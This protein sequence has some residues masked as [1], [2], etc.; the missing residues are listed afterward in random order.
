MHGVSRQVGPALIVVQPGLATTVQDRG[1]PGWQR[2]GVPVSG[3]LDV[4]ALAAA[5]VVV[6]NEIGEAGLECLYRGPELAVR[7]ESVRFAVAGAG[8]GLDVLDADGALIRRCGALESITAAHGERVRVRG[9][10]GS[11]SAYLAIEG[12][13]AVAP[14]LGSRSTY[15]RAGLGGFHGR[16]LRAGDRL[17]LVQ[18]SVCERR[19][20]RLPGVLLEPAETARVAP[21]PQDD[22]FTEDA[23]EALRCGRFTVLPASDRMGLRLMGP[24]LD[25]KA[26]ADIASDGIPPGAVQV[27]GDGQ[28]IVMLADRQTT[29]GY[30]KI[31]TVISVDLPRL[32]RL[33]PGAEVRFEIVSVEMAE[34][35]AREMAAEIARWPQRLAPVAARGEA[36]TLL[37]E[38]NLISG[39]V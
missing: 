6:G 12:G 21:G 23:H 10:G 32:G 38:A 36:V 26:G 31:A 33:G 15:V 39:V 34:A 4:V 13:I 7:A 9:G 29:G 16:H 20:V 37:G 19:E 30:A 3:A 5:N 28:P 8:A 35:M 22:H 1:R 24:R 11:I 17:A 2:F 14:V 18:A 25:H 27:P